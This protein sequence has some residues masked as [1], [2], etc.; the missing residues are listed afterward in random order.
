MLFLHPHSLTSYMIEG[1]TNLLLYFLCLRF[2]AIPPV[3][4]IWLVFRIC[5]TAVPCYCVCLNQAPSFIF[6]FSSF[7]KNRQSV[8]YC[9]W[10]FLSKRKA[11]LVNQKLW[12]QTLTSAM[13]EILHPHFMVIFPSRITYLDPVE[14]YFAHLYSWSQIVICL[15][16]DRIWVLTS[17]AAHTGVSQE[18][19]FSTRIYVSNPLT[20]WTIPDHQSKSHPFGTVQPCPGPVGWRSSINRLL[21]LTDFFLMQFYSLEFSENTYAS[22]TS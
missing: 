1:L 2:A 9:V 22:G 21:T 16:Q 3:M 14:N 8:M 15:H 4:V 11:Y 17:A 12:F 6:P 5:L 20:A 18:S 13:H 19:G 7:P 10:L